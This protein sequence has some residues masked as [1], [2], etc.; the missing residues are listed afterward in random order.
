LYQSTRASIRTSFNLL[1]RQRST[2]TPA[3]G[4]LADEV[5]AR[6]QELLHQ[7]GSL[8]TEKIE[9]WRIRIHGDYHLGQV[10]FTG[11]DFVMIDFEGEPQRPLSERRIKRIAL[12]DVAGMLRSY[13]YTTLMALRTAIETG[14]EEADHAALLADWADTINRW[15]AASF[16]RGYLDAVDGHL[17]VPANERH[18]RWMLD[19][20]Q[21]D[22]AA[23]ELG[24]ELNNRPDWVEIPLRGLLMASTSYV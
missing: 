8:T 16:L 14:V 19:A 20:Y 15:L 4:E 11:N 1:R 2:L 24:Y 3:V 17:L 13:Q 5:L 23:Y 9:A 12:R 10:L 7:L 6:E 18:L 22:K 21:L